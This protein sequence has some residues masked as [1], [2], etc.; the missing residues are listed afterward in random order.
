MIR[1]LSGNPYI[2][3]DVCDISRCKLTSKCSSARGAPST[4][5]GSWSGVSAG[6]VSCLRAISKI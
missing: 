3:A 6:A 4:W 1:S 2:I 5:Y